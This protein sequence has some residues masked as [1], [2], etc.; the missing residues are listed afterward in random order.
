M[1]QHLLNLLLSPMMLVAAGTYAGDT[2]DYPD[3]YRTWTH[4]KTMVLH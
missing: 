1:K 2:V 3:G 4:I